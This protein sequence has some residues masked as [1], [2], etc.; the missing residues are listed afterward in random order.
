[1]SAVL[2][3]A[4]DVSEAVIVGIICFFLGI[5]GTYLKLAN[6]YPATAFSLSEKKEAPF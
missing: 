5:V 4:E 1:M 6:F 2:G 3:F